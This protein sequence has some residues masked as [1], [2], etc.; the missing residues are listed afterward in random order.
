MPPH[1]ARLSGRLRG[2]QRF[3]DGWLVEFGIC[4]DEFTGIKESLL[5]TNLEICTFVLINQ[6]LV[7]DGSANNL[8]AV[9]I[10]P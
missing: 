6:R 4:W 2:F 5:E 1:K 7:F 10:A 3:W 9:L 8:A